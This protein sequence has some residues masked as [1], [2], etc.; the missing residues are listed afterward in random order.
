MTQQTQDRAITLPLLCGLSEEGVRL[1]DGG[2]FTVTVVPPGLL[3]LSP[4]AGDDQERL[5]EHWDEPEEG[6]ARSGGQD[7]GGGE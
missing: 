6:R 7:E 4:A 1:L 5:E 2:T 3:S